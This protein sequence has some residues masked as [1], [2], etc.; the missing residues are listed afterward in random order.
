MKILHVCETVIGG[1]ASYLNILA[2]LSPEHE[3]NFL[4]PEDH[5]E[6]LNPE[7][8]VSSYPSTGRNISTILTH[9][10]ALY[11]EVSAQKPAIVFFHST[12]TLLGLLML[13]VLGSRCKM[14]Y[15][16][17]GWAISRYRK[18][19]IKAR[20][21]GL[22]E[23]NLCGLADVVINISQSD[24]LLAKKLGYRGRHITIENAVQDR[25]FSAQADLFRKETEK[26]H[27]LFVGRHDRQ[28]GLDIL[29]EAFARAHKKRPDL[30]LHI[31][32]KVVQSNGRATILPEGASEA[33]WVRADQI[34][35]WYSSAN[36]LVVPSRWEGFGLVVPEAFRN[37]T[38]ALVSNRGALP[39]LV[40]SGETGEIF[41][42]YIEELSQCLQRLDKVKLDQMGRVCREVY[43]ARFSIPRFSAEVLSVY[44]ELTQHDVLSK[45]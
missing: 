29:I 36:V 41:E 10:R 16:P 25:S 32:G 44:R 12:F 43:E 5:M 1:V 30:R 11:N 6:D 17:H 9:L 40:K 34:D 19:S 23:G 3:N 26:T 38:P 31:L 24:R 15:C 28:K 13:R 33:G 7:L 27:L 18:G 4:I 37:N 22:I 2:T 39:S 21:V 20:F 42:P 8:Q 35:S 45:S 14:V